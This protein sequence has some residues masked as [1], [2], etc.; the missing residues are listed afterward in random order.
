ML[1]AL[2]PLAPDSQPTPA[3]VPTKT[4][5]VDRTET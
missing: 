3:A 1:G 2:P 5:G 4:E